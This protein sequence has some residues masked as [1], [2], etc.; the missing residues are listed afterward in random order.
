MTPR[1]DTPLLKRINTQ[2]PK[3]IVPE[4]VRRMNEGKLPAKELKEAA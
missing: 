4:W 3:R 1:N 2:P